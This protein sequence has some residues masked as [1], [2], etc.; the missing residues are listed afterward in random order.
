M[1]PSGKQLTAATAVT[2]LVLLAA[3]LWTQS[4]LGASLLPHSFCIT[5]SPPLLWLHLISD[6][7]ITLAYLLIPAA[8]VSFI[9]RRKDVPFGWIAW[10]FGAFIV[11]CGM[12]H[13]VE[14]WTL[15]Y[16]VYWYAGV[17]KA[18]TAL[19][20]LGTAW[21]LYTLMPQA[22]ALPSAGQ[23]RAANAALEK[24]IASRRQAEADLVRAKAEVEA[25]LG[26]T[27]AEA[28]R[29]AAILDRFF[30]VA[31]LGM[32]LADEKLTVMRVNP[33]LPQVTRRPEFAY[34][35]ARF[36]E[37]PR[38]PAE[39][40]HALEAVRET[41]APKSVT[42]ISRVD[43]ET[44][45]HHMMATYFPIELP[46]GTLL[47]GGIMQ[48][49]TYQRQIERQREEALA[50]AEEAS[51]AKDQ[52]LAKVSHELRSPLQ[53]ALS[54]VEVL[55]RLPDASGQAR[56]FLDRLAHSVSMQ[57]RMI[58]DLVDVSRI[59]SGKLHVAIETVDP[60]ESLHRVLHHWVNV[61]QQRGIQ[62]EVRNLEPG[63]VLVEADPARLE[64]VYANLLDNAIRFSDENGRIEV[65]AYSSRSHWRF[66]VRDYGAGLDPED[67]ARVFQP[68]VQ[69]GQQ[70]RTGKG[71]GLGLTIV[72]SLVEAF[73][74]RVWAESAGP[75]QGSTFVVELPVPGADSAPPL[76][77][78]FDT[79]PP[80]LDGLRILYVE[81]EV[82]VGQAMQEGL[83][84][85]GAEVHVA[86]SYSEALA[87]L[88]HASP[89]VVVT[90]LNLGDG[91]G[92]HAVAAAVRDIREF[93]AVPIVAVSALG[94]RHDVASTQQ[95]G[96][97][98]HLVKPVD[99]LTVAQ[100][101]CRLVER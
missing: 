82:A 54:S 92:G 22:L 81:D 97:S 34:V 69:G 65:G 77:S 62:L 66:F 63:A 75:R 57:G 3:G 46:G 51:H 25:L 68:F 5:A 53:V 38:M 48:D 52:F 73:G 23:L 64:Q 44:A 4:R 7:L 79:E 59:L 94:T 20:S 61:A 32:L 91:P 101:V 49:V 13:A 76:S 33:A 21:M 43:N 95:A 35:G 55:K 83:Q 50:K 67:A 96:F 45:E 87:R 8:M 88:G 14:V 41:R 89:H 12:T 98:D 29:T 18:F 2:G 6:S 85:L 47:L 1:A 30:E 17:L 56:K 36:G 60:V 10:L 28:Q 40:V 70:P 37:E 71:L 39:A 15:W 27:T 9:R 11:A 19:V 90:D 84:R 93:A 42:Q 31:P 78:A 99:A 26:R 16:P 74:G 24:E 72:K 86:E 58:N 80:R 100:A